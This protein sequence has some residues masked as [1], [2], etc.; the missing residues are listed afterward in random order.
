MIGVREGGRRLATIDTRT[1]AVSPAVTEGASRAVPWKFPLLIAL[2]ALALAAA[3]AV[4]LVR[5]SYRASPS[6]RI[7]RL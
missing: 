1:F 3:C 4:V 2:G 7:A 5:R 6:A